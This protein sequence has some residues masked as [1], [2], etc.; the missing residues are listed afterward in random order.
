M[1]RLRSLTVL[2]AL[3]YEAQR[4]A[5]ELTLRPRHV[6]RERYILLNTRARSY[7]EGGDVV[8]RARAS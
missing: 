1:H 6:S 2:I 4:H 7:L 5:R 8:E 3:F